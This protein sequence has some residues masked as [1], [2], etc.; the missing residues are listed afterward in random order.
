VTKLFNKIYS[1]VS[2]KAISEY[3]TGRYTQFINAHNGLQKLKLK[4]KKNSNQGLEA[5]GTSHKQTQNHRYGDNRT[6][7][8]GFAYRI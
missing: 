1:S 8:A 7:A 3:M 5:Q 2:P 6:M 4:C